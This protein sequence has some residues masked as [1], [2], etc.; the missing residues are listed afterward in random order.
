[1]MGASDT[2]SQLYY[3]FGGRFTRKAINQQ[4]YIISR[5]REFSQKLCKQ[6]DVL[7][8]DELHTIYLPGQYVQGTL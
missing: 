3:F 4:I 5:Q 8:P 6:N 7:S 2:H 1:M